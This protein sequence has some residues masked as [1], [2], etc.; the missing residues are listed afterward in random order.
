MPHTQPAKMIWLALSSS[1]L[2]VAALC[3]QGFQA[4]K[5][6]HEVDELL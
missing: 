4:S 3:E 2:P 6:A 1:S 5:E